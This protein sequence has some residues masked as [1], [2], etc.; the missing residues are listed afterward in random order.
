MAD[1]IGI[2]GALKLG[3]EDARTGSGTEDAKVKDEQQLVHNGNAAH[4]QRAH[5]ADHDVVQQG[6]KIGDAVLN[7]DGDDNGHDPFVKRLVANVPFV[8]SDLSL[9]Y[10]NVVLRFYHGKLGKARVIIMI[11]GSFYAHAL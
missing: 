6:D 5:L 3:G 11:W 10:F 1:A 9:L 7:D 2:A 8:H 4:G